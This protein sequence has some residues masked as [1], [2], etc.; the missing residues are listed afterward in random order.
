MNNGLNV[1][2]EIGKL[3]T[4]LLHRPDFE[5]ENL[6]PDILERL[7]FDDIPYLKIAQE[8][9][10]AFAKILRDNG[11]EV[12]YL[13]DL[14]AESLINDEVRNNF[15]MDFVN[16][17]KFVGK[18]RDM[19][20]KFLSDIKDNKELV[21]KMM[22]GIR[23]DEVKGYRGSFFDVFDYDYPFAVDPMPN[24][25]FT[26]DSFSIIG[27]GV[28]I[29]HM[30]TVTRSRETL[31]GKYIFKYNFRFKDKAVPIWYNRDDT[32][33][34]EGGDILIL[35]K[36][37]VAV[38]IS[39]RT[40]AESV[41]KLAKN[42]FSN[43]EFF[44]T[45]LAFNIPRKRAFM[46]LDTVFTMIDIDKFVMHPEIEGPLTTYAIKKKNA[47]DL[48]IELENI[49]IDKLLAKYLNLDKVS[50]I[51]CGGDD[52]IA[53][54]R[55]QWN[56]GSNTLAIS[57]GEVI[58]YSRNIVTNKILEDSG[59]K[60]HTMPSSELSRGRGGPRCMSMPFDRDDL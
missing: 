58:C 8:E 13:A 17:L 50:V 60:I 20:L 53:S 10:D 33:C 44:K 43:N 39:E 28:S 51:K 40:D 5:L 45:I 42:L 4:V 3:K 15:I 2:S 14:A 38:G 24:L 55:E 1:Y 59:I 49:D 52:L 32:T 21:S 57:P 26:R 47:N 37:T 46:H 18:K 36:D 19:I 23:K 12:L 48:S 9:H 56:D 11:V 27:N 34:I 22:A 31:F 6:I 54:S 30:R 16:D 7:L 41:E 25:Y 29:N 35:S